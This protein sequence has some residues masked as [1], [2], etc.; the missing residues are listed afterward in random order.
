MRCKFDSGF[1]DLWSRAQ[2]GRNLLKRSRG[3]ELFQKTMFAVSDAREYAMGHDLTP[4][5]LGY[6]NTFDARACRYPA[7]AATLG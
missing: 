5:I 6:G 4:G 3:G 1:L 7:L 2:I